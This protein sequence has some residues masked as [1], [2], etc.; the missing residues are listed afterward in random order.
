MT[1]RFLVLA[2]LAACLALL[3]L[4]WGDTGFAPADLAGFLRGDRIATTIVGDIRG[5]RTAVAALVGAGLGVAGAITQAVMRNPLASPGLLGISSGAGLG[6][7]ALVVLVSGPTGHLM[8]VA[9]FAGAALAAVSIYGLSWRQGTSSIRLILMGIGLG[10]LTGAGTTLL[11]I[12]G[13]IRDVQRALAWAAGSVYGADWTRAHWLAAWLFPGFVCAGLMVRDLDLL[14]F[15]D[16]SAAS[17]GLR[18]HL[19]QAILLLA[20]TILAGAAVAASG[21]IA[22]VGLIAPHLAR[23]TSA[24]HAGLLPLAALWGAVMMLGADMAGRFA[25]LPAGLL[26]PIIGAPFVAYLIWKRRNE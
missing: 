17:L 1:S 3:S 19:S 18:V 11:T 13:D 14:T 20:C 2:T 5:P 26:T 4:A 12:S 21:P 25:Q 7:T 16:E 24:R 10:A 8:P 9:G 6:V 15:D 22:F 23:R